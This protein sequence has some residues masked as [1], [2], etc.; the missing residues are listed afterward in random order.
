MRIILAMIL[1]CAAWLMAGLPAAHGESL[2]PEHVRVS[3]EEY[4]HLGGWG[5]ANEFVIHWLDRDKL[6]QLSNR[7]ARLKFNMNSRLS[8]INGVN[9]WLCFPLLYRGGKAYIS[10]LDL[11]KTIAP[12]LSP[13]SYPSG[14]RLKTLCLDPGHGGKDPG[15]RVGGNE[16]KKYTLLL[17][18]ELRGQLEKAGFKVVLTR[19]TDTYVDLGE[20]TAQAKKHKADL[21]VSLHFNSTESS[22]NAV[23]G[24]ETYCLTPAGA[25]STN[26][27]GEGN[28]RWVAGN[29]NDE[30]SMVLAY[31]VQKAL[32]DELSTDDR[33]VR[34]ARFQVLREAQMPAILI[35]G[36]F[37]SNPA[38]S[39]KIF[40]P[41][42]RA[43]MARAI[44]DG[45]IAYK[46]LVKG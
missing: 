4:V 10:Q 35:E 43:R 21:F 9:V 8:E 30:K 18:R 12:L 34:R 15:N 2:R 41:T 37:M 40:N 20:R 27:R 45:I 33:G 29:R 5:R 24:I 7:R 38:E 42:Y 28:T 1:S 22:R 16:E 26:T 17:A 23:K 19:N 13:P 31:Q 46:R 36:G 44:L 25:T 11:E 39:R 3:G 14:I 32:A 6:L